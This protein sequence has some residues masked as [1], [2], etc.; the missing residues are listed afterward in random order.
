MAEITW[1]LSIN[2]YEGKNALSELIAEGLVERVPVLSYGE[3]RLIAR[4]FDMSRINQGGF[5]NFAKK[6][7]FAI[8]NKGKESLGIPITEITKGWK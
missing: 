1:D 2:D 4:V 8:S 3:P 7:W 5:A 6:R